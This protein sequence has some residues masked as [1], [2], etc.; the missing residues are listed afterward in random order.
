MHQQHYSAAN[1]T[2]AFQQGVGRNND[3]MFHN[4]DSLNAPS[5]AGGAKH[6]HNLGVGGGR[7]YT[8]KHNMPY[9]T[10]NYTNYPSCH[11]DYMQ[12]QQQTGGLSAFHYPA[13][14]HH[15]HP[16]TMI[17]PHAHQQSKQT[18][19]SSRYNNQH[20]NNYYRNNHNNNSNRR[21][22]QHHN[23]YNNKTCAMNNDIIKS[24]KII[25]A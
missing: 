10:S 8:N 24:L 5:S 18:N 2:D 12:Q 23:R 4:N 16:N 22:H 9:S 21:D 7:N 1:T 19:R 6:H 11:Q 25:I 15:N 20:Q 17:H 13:Q 3:A 14:V